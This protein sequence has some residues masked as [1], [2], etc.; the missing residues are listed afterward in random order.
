MDLLLISVCLSILPPP[1]PPLSLLRT[2]LSAPAQVQRQ[3]MQL[4]KM[5]L[6]LL[7]HYCQPQ[8]WPKLVKAVSD[9]DVGLEQPNSTGLSSLVQGDPRDATGSGPTATSS[10]AKVPVN[11]QATIWLQ[12]ICANTL[13]YCRHYISPLCKIAVSFV[14][15]VNSTY[16]H[17]IAQG[18]RLHLMKVLT[19]FLLDFVF[20]G[21][22]EPLCIAITVDIVLVP[23]HVAR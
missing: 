1:P 6:G 12:Q 18:L 14:N 10:A 16:A 13:T 20:I 17:S 15:A 9:N 5:M 11:E 23:V 7:P 21:R 3:H 22:S 4:K 2:D 19:G 8:A